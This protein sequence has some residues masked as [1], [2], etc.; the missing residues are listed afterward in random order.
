MPHKNL[1][2]DLG[3]SI[4]TVNFMSFVH[5][6]PYFY[7]LQEIFPPLKFGEWEIL[8]IFLSSLQPIPVAHSM[9]GLASQVSPSCALDSNS[10]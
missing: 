9:F 6:L 3:Y 2:S 1:D 4:C 10:C 8:P 7:W 5:G